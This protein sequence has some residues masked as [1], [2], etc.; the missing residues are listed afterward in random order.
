[1]FLKCAMDIPVP[2]PILQT[3]AKKTAK[4]LPIEHLQVS[5]RQLELFKMQYDNFHILSGESAVDMQTEWKSKLQKVMSEYPTLNQ[6]MAD[7]MKNVN[8]GNSLTKD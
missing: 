6:F 4:M 3:E 2:G 1:M 5:S 8:S 7:K